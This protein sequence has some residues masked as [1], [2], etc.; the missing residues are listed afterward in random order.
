MRVVRGV[1]GGIGRSSER[2][3]SRSKSKDRKVGERREGEEER[4]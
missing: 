2:S 4:A 3:R 1:G